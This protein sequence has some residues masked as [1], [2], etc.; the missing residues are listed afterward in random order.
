MTTTTPHALRIC[1][2]SYIFF[3]D[4]ADLNGGVPCPYSTTCGT[5]R[6]EENFFVVVRHDEGKKNVGRRS[7]QSPGPRQRSQPANGEFLHMLYTPVVR[8]ECRDNNIVLVR[9]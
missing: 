1:V 7:V 6:N 9:D 4:L 2:A 3:S 5:E 8:V